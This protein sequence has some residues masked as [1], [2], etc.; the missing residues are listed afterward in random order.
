MTKWLYKMEY[1]FRKLGIDNLMLYITGTMLAVYLTENL[2][3]LAVSNFL[4]LSRGLVLQGQVWRLITFIFLP[5]NSGMILWVLLGLYFY[6]FIGNSLENVWGRTRF[7]I[8]YLFGIIG[9]IA[10][11]LITGYGTNMYLNLSMFLAFA[12]LF[13][14]YQIMLFFVLPVKVKYLAYIDAAILFLSFISSDWPGKAAILA[15][16]INLL[17]FFG[18]NFVNWLKDWKRYGKNRLNFRRNARSNQDY[19]R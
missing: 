7:T 18:D 16:V 6:Y 19:W 14:D 5:P 10:A 11:A 3:G 12:A 1:R 4:Y 2:T 8:F 13:P 15:S 17:I 9:A